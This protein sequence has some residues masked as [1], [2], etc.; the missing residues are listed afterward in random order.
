MTGCA[1]SVKMQL[2]NR[3]ASC[4]FAAV[5]AV[6]PV[7]AEAPVTSRG[8][9]V[10]PGAT[11]PTPDESASQAAKEGKGGVDAKTMEVAAIVTLLIAASVIGYS[12]NCACPQNT[13]KAGRS[14]GK[15]AAY[16]KPGGWKPLCFARDVT[17]KMIERFRQTG[18]ASAAL[19]LV[20]QQ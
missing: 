3:I 19:E 1:G 18:T 15:R 12:G 2:A 20:E 10:P 7:L 6:S 14:C 5:L 4:V 16:H 9:T 17:A 8:L 11:Q 13:D